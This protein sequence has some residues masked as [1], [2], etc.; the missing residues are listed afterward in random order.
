MNSSRPLVSILR[1]SLT[2]VFS[3]NLVIGVLNL[4]ALLWFARVLG[5]SILGEFAEMVVALDIIAA[6]LG[7]GFNQAVI[8]DPDDN[9]LYTA[10]FAAITLQSIAFIALASVGYW[11]FPWP[12]QSSLTAAIGALALVIA[13]IIGYYACL[14]YAPLESNLDYRPLVFARLASM[15]GGFIVGVLG[16][17]AGY[18]LLALCIRE[19]ATSLLLLF[20]ILAV[21]RPRCPR[22]YIAIPALC[23]LWDYVAP[24]WS[25]NALE[26]IALRFDYALVGAIL[27]RETLGV[28][29]VVRGA[30]EGI[31]GF[32]VMPIQT[33]LFAYYCKLN[34]KRI[35]TTRIRNLAPSV[36]VVV[37]VLSGVSYWLIPP[38]LV[39]WA[40]SPVYASGAALIPGL[41][42]Y[43]GAIL[44]FENTK[45]I[46]MS[47]H[48]H[49]RAALGRVAQVVLIVLFAVP[50]IRQIGLFGAGMVSGAAALVLAMV[51]TVTTTGINLSNHR[52]KGVRNS[53][54]LR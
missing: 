34:D 5:A 6:I 19:L 47:L 37:A 39:Q 49:G 40:F 54:P 24:L 18:G 25:L 44:W 42:L 32:L 27:G 16:I 45:V 28:Y 31:L 33:V 7:F 51:A 13:R 26:G 4:F 21:R 20:V 52:Q 9:D 2:W 38:S 15:I 17:S 1:R 8:R 3:I 30:V 22:P 23:K 48:R 10:A 12:E 46:A 36:L 43:S 11:L 50:A 35:L 53:Y 14:M 29:Y 41:V